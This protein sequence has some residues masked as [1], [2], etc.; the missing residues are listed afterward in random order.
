[1]RKLWWA[2]VNRRRFEDEMADELQFHVEAL[3]ADLERSGLTHEE[4]TRRARIELG[5]AEH[6]KD[7]LLYTSWSSSRCS[8]MRN[9]ARKRCFRM[10]WR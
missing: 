8:R 6:F 3:A 5:C 4:A 9:C 7:C 2:I 1:M 10:R